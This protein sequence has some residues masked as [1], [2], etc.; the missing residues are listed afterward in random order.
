MSEVNVLEKLL[1][2]GSLDDEDGKVR[3]IAQLAVDKGFDHLSEPQ[4]N[5]LRPHLTKACDGVT[6]PGG[7]H[8]DCQTV[9]ESDELATALENQA[10]YGSLLCEK[11]IDEAEQYARE[12][13]RIDRE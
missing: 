7:Y 10:Y 1:K 3:G 9:L 11:C 5:V 8:N 4:K 2:T 6:D 12:W 13:E